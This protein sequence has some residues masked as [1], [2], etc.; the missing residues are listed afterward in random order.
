MI[1]SSY[2]LSLPRPTRNLPVVP[3][4]LL[5]EPRAARSSRPALRIPTAVMGRNQGWGRTDTDQAVDQPLLQAGR[6]AGF[7]LLQAPA[8]RGG[9]RALGLLLLLLPFYCFT[10]QMST[11]YDSCRNA[12]IS[13]SVV[14]KHYNIIL[15]ASKPIPTTNPTDKQ[16]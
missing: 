3:P 12:K 15:G 4:S 7:I 13:W 9:F 2:H 6:A 8:R 1:E 5:W 14:H 10:I 11:V 16:S